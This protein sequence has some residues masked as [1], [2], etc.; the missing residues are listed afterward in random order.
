[1]HRAVR[2]PEYAGRCA[3]AAV[4][5]RDGSIEARVGTALLGQALIGAAS[6]ASPKK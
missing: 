4:L 1:M 5:D 3:I 6:W 2:N